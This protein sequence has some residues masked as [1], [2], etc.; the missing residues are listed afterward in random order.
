MS[1]NARYLREEL[2]ELLALNCL[3]KKN[4]DVTFQSEKMAEVEVSGQDQ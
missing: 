3:Q 1:F 2:S 4:R